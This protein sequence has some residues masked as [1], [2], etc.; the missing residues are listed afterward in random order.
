[1]NNTNTSNRTI[2]LI[3][4]IIA[5]LLLCGCLIIA[6]IGAAGY[7]ASRA[8]EPTY[9]DFSPTYDFEELPTQGPAPT[10]AASPAPPEA[11]DVLAALEAAEIP[12]RDRY[13]LA[14]RFLD[15]DDATVEPPGEYAVGDRINFWMESDVTEQAVE[16]EAEMVYKNDVVYMWVEVG[17]DFDHNALVQ[18]ADLFAERTYPTN[19]E[20]FGSEPSPGIDGDPRLHILNYYEEATNV[21]GS[22]YSPSEYPREIVPTSNEKEIFYINIANTPPSDDYYNTVLAHEFQHMIHW[23][24]DRNEESWINEGLSEV[25]VYLNGMGPSD[26]T[27][28]YFFDPDLQLNTWP[29][30]SDTSPH[31]AAGFLFGVYF[32]D[33]FGEEGLRALVAHSGNGFAGVE[34][35]LEEIGASESGDDVFEDWAIANYLNDRNV[36][37]E[38]GYAELD[39]PGPELAG[40]HSSYPVTADG[41]TVHQYGVDYIELTGNG[42]LTIRF[43]GTTQVKIIPANTANTDGDPATDDSYVWWS[44]RADDSNP[45]LTRS[46][47]LTGVTSATLEYDAWYWIEDRWD[48][49]FVSVSADDGDSWTILETP[50][51]TTDDP[52][53]NSYGPGYTARST[54]QSGANPDG[55]LHESID[56]SGYAGQEILLRFEL[57]TDDA[58]NQPGLAIDNICIAEIDWCDDAEVD[59]GSWETLGFVR[60]NNLL[61]QNFRVQVMVPD[62]S[63]G[64][65]VGQVALDETNHGEITVT[66]P[67]RDPAILVVSGT[68]RYITELAVYRYEITAGP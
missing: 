39:L 61:A 17:R 40:S 9:V 25:A 58:V 31:Y 29:E 67:G 60:H 8:I 65:T 15:I 22:F 57:L 44:N 33:R 34:A 26:A 36:G 38:Y 16:I 11:S 18:A 30:D 23:A 54:D 10:I 46:I 62:G 12:A 56:L 45:M 63:G 27:P 47:D 6:G 55:W 50:Y 42:P 64:Y 66:L 37:P 24:V 32:H 20:N 5:V 2:L 19:R 4:G 28:F 35:A 51:T 1:M 21:A 14:A 43:D 53:G 48:F 7:L 3:G 52:H 41:Q 68:T 49:A 13:D 59:D